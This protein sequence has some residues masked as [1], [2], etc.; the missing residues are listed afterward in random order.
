MSERKGR[1]RKREIKK[2]YGKRRV[3]GRFRALCRSPRLRNCVCATLFAQQLEVGILPPR[4]S[5]PHAAQVRKGEELRCLFIVVDEYPGERLVGWLAG[6]Q[7]GTHPP[8]P[9][10]LFVYKRADHR[11]HPSVNRAHTWPIVVRYIHLYVMYPRLRSSFAAKRGIHRY[12]ANRCG[13]LIQ[14]RRYFCKVKNL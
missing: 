1:K 3:I 13:K 5:P 9:P 2:G 6:G 4:K 14:N 11:R 10:R 12:R 8:H 7:A